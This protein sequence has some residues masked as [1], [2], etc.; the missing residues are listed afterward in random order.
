MH[1]TSPA[2]RMFDEIA[3][4]NGAKDVQCEEYVHIA[5]RKICD[6][7]TLRDVLKAYKTYNPVS[8]VCKYFPYHLWC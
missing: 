1:L 8:L 3:T 6:T 2:V 7:D 4:Q 5:S